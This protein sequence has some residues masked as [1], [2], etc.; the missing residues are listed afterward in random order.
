M[1]APLTFRGRLPGVVCEAALPVSPEN[2]LRLDVAAFVGFAERGPLDLPVAVE[3]ISQYQAVFGNDLLLART[4]KGQPVFANLP[5]TVRSFFDN[6]GRRCY[7]VRVA[8]DTIARANR[9]RMP[10]LVAWDSNAQT[11]KTVIVPAAWVGRWSDSMSVGTQLRSS[12][13]RLGVTPPAWTDSLE[14]S[15]EVPTRTTVLP[16]DLLRLHF[17]GAGKPILFV[18]VDSVVQTS[19]AA[20]TTRGIPVTV[21][22]QPE[23]VFA[24]TSNP[25]APLPVPLSVE[26]QKG[27]IWESMQASLSPLE[28]LPDLVDGYAL[29]MTTP[30]SV[31]KDDVLRLTCTN[32][33]VLFFTVSSVE[34]ADSSPPAER[35]LRLV[36]RTPRWQF[37]PIKVERLTEAGYTELSS[38]IP[39]LDAQLGRNKEYT[40]YLP[41]ME[42]VQVGDLLQVT[43]MGDRVILFP[44]ED[45]EL[46]QDTSLPV[47]SPPERAA[48]VSPPGPP[49]L[50]VISR[51]P[52]WKAP[53]PV[54]PPDEGMYGE[55]E[56]VD[57]LSFD[58]LIREGQEIEEIW[59][60]LRFG[61]GPNYWVDKLVP[62]PPT[63]GG[64]ISLVPTNG[65]RS[66]RSI[67][68]LDPTRSSR[69]G[70]PLPITD[71]PGA[72][73]PLYLPL[74]MGD[75]P[76]PDEFA[77]PLPDAGTVNPLCPLASKDGLESFD[78][79]AELF[80]DP[81]LASVGMRDLLN[82][83]NALLYLNNGAPADPLRKLH[84]LLLIDE[85]GLISL[86]D[87]VHRRWICEGPEP[88]ILTSPPEP[89]P[90]D[91]S[92]F[93]DCPEPP[94]SPPEEQTPCGEP[95]PFSSPPAEVELPDIRQQLNGLPVLE[96]EDQYQ[97]DE[98]NEL[99]A[100]QQ[101]LVN[102]C[103]ARADVL[104][105]LSLP[106][107]F[108]RREVLDWQRIFTTGIPDVLDGSALSY[109]AV[110]HPWLQGRE[111]IT[112]ELAPLRATP[113]DGAV[114]GMIA[115]R[116]LSRGPWIAPANVPLLGVVG[117]TPLLTTDDWY[118]LFNAQ[119]NVVRQKPGQF[120]LLSAFT[121]S[122]DDQLVQI[123]VRRLMIFLRK[124]AFRRGMRYVFEANNER[125]RQRV[126]ASFE[127][128]L[129][130]MAVRGA[131]T[132]F[133]VVTSSEINTPNDYDN[134]RFLIAL[135]VAPTLPIEFITVILLRAGEGL[136]EVIE[137]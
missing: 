42:N 76:G 68:G 90:P 117:L 57:L 137:G 8:D 120:T 63:D 30:A 134:G 109:V 51:M 50:R 124:L 47:T 127:H 33:D 14:V 4:S 32:G 46:Q 74:G 123:S 105:V 104:G 115:A 38:L 26:K 99:L 15:L 106:L 54:S 41:T 21:E 89:L 130:L 61:A 36:S 44:V 122:L 20:A 23:T 128:T 65:D 108:K 52:L 6:G 113:P 37:T 92:C 5:Q 39:P 133:E 3:D 107:H 96:Q 31:L 62:P 75:L 118:E 83:A 93:Q 9:F 22:A 67:P 95:I 48:D 103:A 88:E 78:K 132:A 69:L 45:V 55:L 110:Y 16:N 18:A 10:G 60:E 7:V 13:L 59:R 116:E 81:R 131:L 114:C 71:V 73:P 126:Q 72:P 85:I 2:P 129:T 80:L 97:Q 119:M 58:L 98:L 135:K 94:A 100:V 27:Q 49:S 53:Q 82:E 77:R 35:S 17:G 112:P 102:F 12:P 25:G 125:F 43:C 111:E 66:Q 87:L 28:E 24:F 136:L 40:L 34:G 79:P 11:L 64:A 86:P 70:M 29:D 101:A 121:L 84:S 1:G 56:Q 19:S 91:W